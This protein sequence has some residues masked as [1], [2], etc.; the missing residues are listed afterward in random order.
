VLLVTLVTGPRE[1]RV[2][3]P[4]LSSEAPRPTTLCAAAS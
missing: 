1:S 2:Q 4:V 3:H